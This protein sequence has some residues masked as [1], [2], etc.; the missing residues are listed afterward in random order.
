MIRRTHIVIV[1]PS[2]IIRSGVVQILKMLGNLDVVIADH[3]H[4]DDL[5]NN[6]LSTPPDIVIVNPAHLSVANF[7]KLNNV[8]SNCKMVALQLT[9]ADASAFKNYSGVISIYD[10]IN[11]IK[12]L[13]TTLINEGNHNEEKVELSVREQEVVAC[14]AKGMSNKQIAEELFLSTYTVMT[15]RRNI[16]NKL[17]IHSPAGL[18]IYAIVNKLID[19]NDMKDALT[20]FAE[21]EDK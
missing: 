5:E 3:P 8:L 6:M 16:S 4:I 14:I 7:S 13:L 18:T 10:S 9:L 2:I 12:E 21:G 15:H 11:T 20:T 1:E 19:V 17:Q